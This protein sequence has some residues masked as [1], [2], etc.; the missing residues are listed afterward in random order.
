MYLTTFMHFYLLVLIGFNRYD[1]NSDNF[2][3]EED[4]R[5]V[6]SYVPFIKDLGTNFESMSSVF[7]AR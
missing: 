1:F 4:A 7:Q 6:L 5:I 2:I 3:Q